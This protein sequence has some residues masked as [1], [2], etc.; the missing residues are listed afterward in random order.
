MFTPAAGPNQVKS[1]CLQVRARDAVLRDDGAVGHAALG[2]GLRA[3]PPGAH[4]QPTP[5]APRV[6]L[7]VRPALQ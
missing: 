5:G 7:Q 3:V 6:L 2:D 4:G 1:A